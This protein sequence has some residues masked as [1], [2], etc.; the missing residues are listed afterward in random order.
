MAVDVFMADWLANKDCASPDSLVR[1][2]MEATKKLFALL[3]EIK[4][5]SRS[6]RP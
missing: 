6:R 2:L 1:R 3:A 5:H 4:R